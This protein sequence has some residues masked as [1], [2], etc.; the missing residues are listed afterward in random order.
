MLVKVIF[1]AVVLFLNSYLY[2]VCQKAPEEGKA[3][4]VLSFLFLFVQLASCSLL[5]FNLNLL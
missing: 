4:D 2:S 1:I 5:Y 3:A